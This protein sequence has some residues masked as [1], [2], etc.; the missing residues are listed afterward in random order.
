MIIQRENSSTSVNKPSPKPPIKPSSPELKFQPLPSNQI[1]KAEDIYKEY[2]NTDISHL[3][4]QFLYKINCGL[5][6][7]FK[8]N[9]KVN[10][11]TDLTKSKVSAIDALGLTYFGRGNMP[12]F[13][14]H[15]SEL[16]MLAV[17]KYANSLKY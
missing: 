3:D 13:K 12:P 16:E 15:L 10:G 5:C 14:S 17:I 11:A 9:A 8:G 7:G 4:S 1:K 6:H 2:S